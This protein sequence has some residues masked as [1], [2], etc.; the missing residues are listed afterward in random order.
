MTGA[1]TLYRTQKI[2]YNAK[3]QYKF[4]PITESVGIYLDAINMFQRILM[5]LMMN[6]NNK[7]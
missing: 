2:I 1:L 6:K 5:I 3:T 7:K 4:D